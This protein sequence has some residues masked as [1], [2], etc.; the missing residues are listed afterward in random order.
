M[1]IKFTPPCLNRYLLEDFKAGKLNCIHARK[2]IITQT[3]MDGTSFIYSE[4]I[5]TEN[6][7]LV[8]S[9]IAQTSKPFV[10]NGCEF[11][12]RTAWVKILV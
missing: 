1:K 3:H 2:T 10:K 6:M 4:K 7:C 11:F 12:Q 8:V 9:Y 5:D